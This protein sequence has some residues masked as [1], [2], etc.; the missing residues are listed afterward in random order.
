M[1]QIQKLM[2]QNT[3]E[4]YKSNRTIIFIG[5]TGINNLNCQFHSDEIVI[6]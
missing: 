2:L 6:A 3:N 4:Y 5:I 1:M